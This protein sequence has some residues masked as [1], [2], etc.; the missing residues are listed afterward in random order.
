MIFVYFCSL[1]FPIYSLINFS[2]SSSYYIVQAHRVFISHQI[3]ANYYRHSN[4]EL[5]SIFDSWRCVRCGDSIKVKI[6][7]CQALSNLTLTSYDMMTP[8]P[9]SDVCRTLTTTTTMKVMWTSRDTT[10]SRRHRRKLT[11][12]SPHTN[13]FSNN[14]GRCSAT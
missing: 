2:I 13:N 12:S 9:V 11:S 14:T 3:L 6:T 4:T 8:A 1:V 10:R 5:F 7:R